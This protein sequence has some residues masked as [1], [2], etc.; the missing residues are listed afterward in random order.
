MDFHQTWYVHWYCW[1]LGSG[2]LMGKFHQFLTELSAWDTFIFSFPDDNLSRC[3]WIFTKLSICIDI[4]E[5][6]FGIADWVDFVNFWQSYLPAHDNGQVLSFHIFNLYNLNIF[7]QIQ[8]LLGSC[9]TLKVL[10][11]IAADSIFRENKISISCE[12]SAKQMIHK[13]C[14]N[15][16][17][18]CC[19]SD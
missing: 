17:V 13:K 5:I 15:K 3:H 8:N 7:V 14:Q 12:L 2:L 16:K 19:N 4:V 18:I 6:W 11:E 1:D 10:S 9:L